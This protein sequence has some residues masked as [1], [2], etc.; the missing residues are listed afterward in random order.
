MT[1]VMTGSVYD[2]SNTVCNDFKGTKQEMEDYELSGNSVTHGG[3]YTI[4]QETHCY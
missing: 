2:N 4:T 3:N 1:T